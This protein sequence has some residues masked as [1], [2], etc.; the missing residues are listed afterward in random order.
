MRRASV[1]WPS[2]PVYRNRANVIHANLDFRACEVARIIRNLALVCLSPNSFSMLTVFKLI[3]YC[4]SW[5][6][7]CREGAQLLK[8]RRLC[9]LLTLLNGLT[10]KTSFRYNY[11]WNYSSFIRCENCEGFCFS[12]NSSTLAYRFQ[13]SC[14]RASRNFFP[15]RR[16]PPPNVQR[17]PNEVGTPAVFRRQ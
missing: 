9:S 8:L 10:E 3:F 7:R 14:I 6:G 4:T 11:F 15:A 12:C 1:L 17:F 5:V 2:S 16:S 13:D